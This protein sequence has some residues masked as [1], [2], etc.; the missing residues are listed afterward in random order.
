MSVRAAL[1]KLPERYTSP[2]IT[3]DDFDFTR[4]PV[5][6]PAVGAWR[7]VPAWL[8]VLLI[9]VFSRI[10]TTVVMLIYAG[11]QEE[12]W[13][14]PANP[15]YFTFANIWDGDWYRYIAQAGYPVDLPIN[16]QGLVTENSW[17]FMPVYPF[18]VRGIS[19]VTT[20]PFGV[21]TVLVS[22][23][24]G[25]G[26]A[27]GLFSLLR[28]FASQNVS[29]FAVFLLCIGPVSP[30]FQVGYAEALHFWMLTVLLQQLVDRRW[31]AMIPLVAIASF[32]RPT[33]LAWA[34]TLFLYI[35]YRYWNR[36]RAR[37]EAFPKREQQQ[38]WGVAVFSGLM[39]LAWLIIAG[40][41]TRFPEA[42]LE[43]E[44]AWRRHYTGGEHTP[45]FTSWFYGADFWF[46]PIMGAILVLAIVALMAVWLGSRTLS[47]FGIEIRLW[48][49]AYFSYIFAVFFPQSST[50]RIL[51]PLFPAAAVVALPRSPLYRVLVSLGAFLA[52]VLWLHW[53]WFVI[54]RD[55]TPP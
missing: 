12:T 43:T 37:L 21:C 13:Q 34:F 31:L 23:V 15:D 26:C 55:W 42:Y 48:S 54:G 6:G 50:F 28:R 51:F 22:L 7:R 19:I 8:Q 11:N 49:I 44:F 53:M 52:Q 35:L 5:F 27:Y 4:Q 18:L 17:A 30:L 14:T 1:P 36:Y 40:V 32:T 24:A 47:R 2:A 38:L 41:V 39:G 16:E 45:P 33:G 20:L 25:L 46:G 3:R 9:Y 29:M 10:V